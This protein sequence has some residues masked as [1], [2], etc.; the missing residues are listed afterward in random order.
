MKPTLIKYFGIFLIINFAALALGGLATSEAVSGQ[1]YQTIN[2]APGTPPGW[3]FGAAWTTIMLCF[4]IFMAFTWDAATDKKKLATL[5]GI[6]W[7]LNVSW[8]PVFFVY[9][10]VVF[11]LIMIIALTC[12]VGYFLFN[13][14]SILKVKA[15]LILPYFVWMLIATSLNLYIMLYN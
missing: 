10:Y 3:V 11:G 5:F 7:V 15:V 9:H 13:Y 4:S 2:K 6:Q 14:R 12:L 1:W 8:N